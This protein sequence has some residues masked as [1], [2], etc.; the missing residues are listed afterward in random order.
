VSFHAPLYKVDAETDAV[1]VGLD[2]GSYVVGMK[3][4]LDDGLILL[5]FPGFGE[6]DP[7][8]LGFDAHDRPI[9]PLRF[10]LALGR[11][12]QTQWYTGVPENATV[13]AVDLAAGTAHV[14]FTGTRTFAL[15]YD[16]HA[17]F[18]TQLDIDGYGGYKVTAHGYGFHGH[19]VVPSHQDLVFCN[20]RQAG[21]QAVDFCVT[22]SA[23][24]PQAPTLTVAVKG[25][26][27]R[28]SFGLFLRDTEA[29]PV[30]PGVLAIRVTAP[31]GSVY[32]ASKDPST[33]GMVMYPHGLEHPQ[34]TWQ[35]TSVAAG[36][37]LAILEGVAYKVLDV[38]L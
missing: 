14:S 24:D 8:T 5:H 35:V 6:V 19:V 20:G 34:G 18:V 10:P 33:T 2:N 32:Q 16:A 1:V 17:G 30:G 27:D 38:D 28:V 12:W 37:G 23:L 21:V 31:D 7:A 11:S 3:D 13:D 36:E 25:P 9:A 26:Y 15:T 29:A 22:K 4:Q